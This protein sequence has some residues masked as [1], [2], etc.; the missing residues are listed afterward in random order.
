MK[1][2]SLFMSS[3]LLS[4][5]CLADVKL[6]STYFSESGNSDKA[7]KST[8]GLCHNAD[9][10]S[11]SRVHVKGDGS[12]VYPSMKAC[13]ESGG[14]E[15]VYYKRTLVDP[16]E[17]QEANL[18]IE[19]GKQEAESR[20]KFAG[21]SWAPAMMLI[22]FHEDIIEDVT[23]E[24]EKIVVL[25][26]VDTKAVWGLESHFF[27]TYGS[28]KQFGAGPFVSIGLVGEDGIDPLSTVGIGLMHGF[29]TSSSTVNS[30]NIGLGYYM[31][32]SA[33]VLREG[34]SDGDATEITDSAKLTKKKKIGGFAV[35]LSAKF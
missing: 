25:H 35:T 2:T 9:S 13:F 27:F 6:A 18:A 11:A 23:I 12:N 5:A 7:V 19:K 16:T 10:P 34:L 30:W 32:T 14:T 20:E 8:T 3:M 22:K 15:P 21:L 1:N 24:D 31:N 4:S 33:I 28:K 29:R 17:E 26:S